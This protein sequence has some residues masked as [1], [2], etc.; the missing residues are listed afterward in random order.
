[1]TT[2]FGRIYGRFSSEPQQRGDSRRRQIDGATAYAKAHGI[3]ILEIYFDEAVSGKAGKN[4]EKEF[5]R[6]LREARKGEAILCEQVDRIGRQHPIEVLNVIKEK[7]VD[8]GLSLHLWQKNLVIDQSNIDNPAIL[9]SLFGETTVGFADNSRKIDRIREDKEK[10]FQ[11]GLKG[12]ATRTLLGHLPECFKWNDSLK[13]IEIEEDRAKAIRNIYKWFND[14]IGRTTIVKRLNQAGVPPIYKKTKSWDETTITGILYN[15]SYAGVLN[16][17]GYRLN[18]I[19]AVVTRTT[20]DK[21]QLFLQRNKTRRGKLSGRIN[22]LFPSIAKC[23]RCQ[24]LMSVAVSVASKNGHK[25]Y[26]YSYCCRNARRGSCETTKGRNARIVEL[27]FLSQYFGGSPN[28]LFVEQS[29]EI[30]EAISALEERRD[31]L[32]AKIENLYDLVEQGDEGAKSRVQRRKLEL[33]EVE[34]EIV[35]K[36]GMLTEQA[37]LPTA[38]DEIAEL[39][40][41]AD[42]PTT[43]ENTEKLEQ[44]LTSFYPKLYAT[45]SQHDVRR[46]LANVMPTIFESVMFDNDAFTLEP[47]RKDGTRLPLVD[48]NTFEDY[49]NKGEHNPNYKHGK[50]SKIRDKKI[51]R[52]SS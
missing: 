35:I 34:S 22:N 44:L 5:G 49:K 43:T 37:Q 14:G 24:G 3:V 48:C 45:L 30:K 7:I 19:P 18:C 10:A 46:K 31:Q 33:Q 29:I 9:F 41:F 36:K 1:M 17:K 16:V 11:V 20:W 26:C 27:V 13:K 51:A 8:K 15:E 42:V 40:D 23:A 28:N 12:V 25:K 39:M 4:L 50:S 38:M 2:T 47:I 32:K 52:Q 6:V 21:A